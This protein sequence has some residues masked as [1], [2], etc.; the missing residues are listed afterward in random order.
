[1]T[2]LLFPS[3]ASTS[4]LSASGPDTFPFTG[5]KSSALGTLPVSEALKTVSI[6]S[7]VSLKDDVAGNVPTQLAALDECNSVTRWLLKSRKSGAWVS[8][9]HRQCA[10]VQLVFETS[11]HLETMSGSNRSSFICYMTCGPTHETI[12]PRVFPRLV[13]ECS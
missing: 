1:M 10:R 2:H 8:E 7:V 5:R 3:A 6:E 9:E 11:F 13:L 4:M 12:S